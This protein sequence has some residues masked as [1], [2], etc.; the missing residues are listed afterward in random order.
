MVAQGHHGASPKAGKS[1]PKRYCFGAGLDVEAFGAG[2][3]NC[4]ILSIFLYFGMFPDFCMPCVGS[5][6]NKLID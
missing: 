4:G 6:C 3:V 5:N 1:V 2:L